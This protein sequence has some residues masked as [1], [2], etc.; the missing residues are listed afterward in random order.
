MVTEGWE[1]ACGPQTGWNKRADSWD[2][3]NTTIT[4]PEEG[5]TPLQ[6]FLQNLP[7]KTLPRKP[8]GSLCFLNISCPIL[9]AINLSLFQTKT[10]QFVWPHCAS[11]TWTW[12][13]QHYIQQHYSTRQDLYW[14]WCQG[15]SNMF[16]GPDRL[17]VCKGQLKNEVLVLVCFI[18]AAMDPKNSPLWS[19]PWSMHAQSRQILLTI[20]KSCNQLG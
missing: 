3:W 15:S 16:L 5:H 8:L 1:Q 18:W 2:S 17:E 4:I 13:Q 6:P 19:F 9:L 7:I 14:H 11:G 10:F 20:D 12:V